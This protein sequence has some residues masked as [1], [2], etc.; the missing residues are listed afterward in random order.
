MANEPSKKELIELGDS[1]LER[2]AIG[3]AIKVYE[4]AGRKLS[5]QDLIKLGDRYCKEDRLDYANDAYNR[6]GFQEGLRKVE[7]RI[8]EE[9]RLSNKG[10]LTKIKNRILSRR[11]I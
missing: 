5:K 3:N 2:G 7:E 8:T 9:G 11:K 1:Y 10:L 6:A 4:R